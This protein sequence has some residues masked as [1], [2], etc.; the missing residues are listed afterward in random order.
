M[1]SQTIPAYVFQ[2]YA[3]DDHIQVWFGQA[4]AMTQYYVSWF[5]S[6]N[7]P[8][9][10]QQSGSL[11]DWI[12]NGLYG[13]YRPTLGGVLS[14]DDIFQRCIT[15]AFYK[16]DGKVFNVRWLKRRI[17]RWLSGPNGV[18]PGVNQT[19][20]ISVTFTLPNICT[21]NILT[22]SGGKSGGTFNTYQYNTTEFNQAYFNISIAS[23]LREAIESGAVE[24]PFMYDYVVKING[25]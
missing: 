15:W 18:D 24:L 2:E 21:I 19:Y 10:T 5:Y 20:Q 22:N 1:L 3:D 16:G 12:A 23:I 4:N 7:L 6:A 17:Q 25:S 14:S 13:Q 11:L 8:I 9:Y